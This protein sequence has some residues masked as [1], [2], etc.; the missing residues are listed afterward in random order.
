MA[1]HDTSEVQASHHGVNRRAR[2]ESPDVRADVDDSRV[3]AGAEHDQAETS[4]VCDEQTLVE[5]KRVRLPGRIRTLS[6]EVVG[7]ALLERRDPRDLPAVVEVAVEQ[8]PL[9][10][11]VDDRRAALL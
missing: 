4:Y 2:K 1:F 3:G 5:Q 7:A 10:R 9:L 6:A 11:R 8:Q